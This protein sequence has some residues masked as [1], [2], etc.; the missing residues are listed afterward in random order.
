[1]RTGKKFQDQD[2]SFFLELTV[3][4]FMIMTIWG[5]LGGCS[6]AKPNADGHPTV[7][8]ASAQISE[9]AAAPAQEA[10]S[11]KV[12]SKVAH[13][14]VKK[15]DTLYRIAQKTGASVDAIA[16]ANGLSDPTRLAV[17]QTLVIPK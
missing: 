1:M 9:P 8:L 17:G 12:E 14:Q 4:L 11:A 2:I 13:Y 5:L 16:M 3:T 7:S 15:G 10:A 6:V